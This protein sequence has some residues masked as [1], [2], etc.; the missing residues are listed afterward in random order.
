MGTEINYTILR[1]GES[2]SGQLVAEEICPV[3][4]ECLRWSFFRAPRLAPKEKYK[5]PSPHCFLPSSALR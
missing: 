5:P 1:L 4:G 3:T 2:A